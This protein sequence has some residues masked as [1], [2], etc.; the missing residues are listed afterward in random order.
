MWVRRSFHYLK[1]LPDLIKPSKRNL[2]H[3]SSGGF[4]QRQVMWSCDTNS[5]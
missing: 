1:P 4:R 2:L 5:Q 3:A